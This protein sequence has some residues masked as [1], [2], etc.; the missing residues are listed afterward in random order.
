MLECVVNVSEGRDPALIAE[1]A[2]AA[3]RSLLDVHSDADHHRSVLTMAGRHVEEDVRRVATVA[4]ARLDLRRHVGV[5]PRLGVL[6]VVPFVVLDDG[7]SPAEPRQLAAAV[8]ARDRMAQWAG[9]QL[10]LPC[11]LYGPERSLP[12]VRRH[13]FVSLAPDCGPDEPHPTAGA[14][15][16]GARP[17]LVA[18]NL[19]LTTAD[20]AAA[21]ALAA[22]VRGP[23]VR[24]LGLAVGR[25]TQVSFNLIDPSTVGPEQAYDAV[26]GAAGAVGI[27]ISRAEVVGLVPSSVVE[28]VSPGRRK[29][30]DLDPERT[31]E[32]RL[33]S[34]RASMR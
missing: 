5:H 3:G 7:G 27:S 23:A 26:A 20:V 14:C 30:L 22:A 1:L 17:V 6:D 21:R 12:E 34:G 9:R 28:A 13:A 19:W 11:F 2:D 18:Y 29:A 15:A 4:V 33:D 10:A 32:A 16:V 8:E 24:A 31:I 25:T